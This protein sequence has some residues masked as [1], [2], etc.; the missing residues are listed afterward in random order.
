MKALSMDR[1]VRTVSVQRWSFVEA[2]V[3]LVLHSFMLGQICMKKYMQKIHVLLNVGLSTSKYTFKFTCSLVAIK[4]K[5][6]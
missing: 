4:T 6:F 3:T 1:H 5:N 2:L